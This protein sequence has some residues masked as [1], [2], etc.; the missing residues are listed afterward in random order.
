MIVRT[1]SVLMKCL[2]P[3]LVRPCIK[4]SLNLSLDGLRII[5]LDT[6]HLNLKKP[7]I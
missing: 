4:V 1:Y 6:E 2:M 7:W 5:L 3:V